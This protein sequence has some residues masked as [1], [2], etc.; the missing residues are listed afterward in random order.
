MTGYGSG[1]AHVEIDGSPIR[2]LVS[3]RAVNHRFLDARVRVPSAMNDHGAAL[4]ELVRKRLARGRVEVSVRTEGRLERP[5]QLDMELARAALAQLKSLRDE[6]APDDPVPLAILS[7]V[8][9]LFTPAAPPDGT[10]LGKALLEAG[11]KACDDLDAM[12]VREGK[13]LAQDLG[14]RLES[15][16]AKL[17]QLAMLCPSVV[18]THRAR[19]YEKIDRILSSRVDGHAEKPIPI[20]ESRLEHEIALYAEKTDV[21]EEVT[22]LRSHC[23]QFSELMQSTGP[24]HGRKLDFLLQEMGREVN[25]LGAKTP[26]IEIT[27][28]VVE[29]KADVERMREQVQNVL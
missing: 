9:G 17:A 13:T 10:A 21:A 8:P 18:E 25:T 6:V 24:V 2:L 20:D 26:D 19:L 29:L 7:N 1:E 14:R 12:R 3:M 11:A 27:R 15:I 4:E 28:V 22:R 23:D 16:R 5:P